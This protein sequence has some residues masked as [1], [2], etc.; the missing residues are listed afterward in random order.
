MYKV[1]EE[2]WA[3]GLAELRL[4]RSQDGRACVPIPGYLPEGGRETDTTHPLELISAGT[5]Q[6]PVLT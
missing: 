2:V 1:R 6:P 5:Q 4:E 3:W